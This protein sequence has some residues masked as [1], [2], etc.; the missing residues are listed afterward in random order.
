MV[1]L[2]NQR[3]APAVISRITGLSE[4]LVSDYMDLS[5]EYDRPEHQSVFKRLMLRFGP[6][7]DEG[8]SDG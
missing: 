1:A 6:L 5:S 4:K 8:A 3:L 2:R 7:H